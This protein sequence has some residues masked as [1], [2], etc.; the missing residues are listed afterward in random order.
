MPTKTSRALLVLS[1]DES[2]LLEELVV[3]RTASVREVERAKILLAY[4]RREPLT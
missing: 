4:S 1:E 3:S 2:R